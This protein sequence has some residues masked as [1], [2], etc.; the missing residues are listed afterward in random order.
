MQ[1]KVDL[2]DTYSAALEGKRPLDFDECP[3]IDAPWYRKRRRETGINDALPGLQM[4]KAEMDPYNEPRH[5]LDRRQLIFY[6][7]TGELPRDPNMHLCAH[8]YASDRNS[9]FIVA[10]HFDIGDANTQ[11]GSLA[12]TVIFHASMDD[13]WFGPSAVA[14]SKLHDRGGRWFCREDSSNRVTD[15][16]GLFHSKL[17]SADGVH[18][19]SILQDGMIR[20]IKKPRASPEEIQASKDRENRWKPRG[21]L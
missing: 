16:R 18:V 7:P 8:L 14:D 10:N 6:R 12:H 4:L 21:K 20:V 2:W 19:S 11:M 9:L 1:E 13:L 15:G 17:L 3:G 5:P